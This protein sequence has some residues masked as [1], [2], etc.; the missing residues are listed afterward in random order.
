MSHPASSFPLADADKCVKCALCLPH[1]PTY[2]ST[3][4]EG[5]SPRGRIALMQGMASGALEVT[6]R[7]TAHL[8]HCLSCRACE[9]V[10]PAEVPYGRL[11]DAARAELRQ[12]GHRE[13]LRA[14]A[15]AHGMHGKG[16]RRFLGAV[17]RL[18]QSLG[19]TGLMQRSGPAALQR[20][21]RL[22]PSI[23]GPQRWKGTYLPHTPNGQSV[24]L[25]LGCLA[26]ITQPQV[27]AAAI[28]VLN[29]LGVEVRIPASQGCCGALDQHA[30]RASKAVRLAETNLAAFGG[31]ATVLGTASGCLATLKDY[32]LMIGEPAAGFASGVQDVSSYIA[33]HGRLAELQFKPWKVRVLVH[34]P[35]TQRNVLKS[36]KWVPE[37]LKHI[38][39]L[40]VDIIPA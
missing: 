34:S 23:P 18:S 17:L 2:R 32:G 7:L 25:F 33:R 10:C 14:L 8:D 5:E 13:P 12:R 20:L 15:F 40:E 1:C 27:S 9:A 38:P 31:D 16:H 35:C 22:L 21:A 36:D 3:L 28:D 37:T 4:D 6:P 19:L 39:D 26:D 11:I 30:G 24:S 29:A